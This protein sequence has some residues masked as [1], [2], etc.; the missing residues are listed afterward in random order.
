MWNN[1]PPANTSLNKFECL[2]NHKGHLERLAQT[3]AV[4]NNKTPKTPSFLKRKIRDAG[5]RMER[6]LKILYENKIISNRMEEISKKKSPYSPSLNIPSQCPAFELLGYHRLKINKVIDRENNKLYKRFTF[7]K[8]TLNSDKLNQE[9]K[10]NKYLE[11]NISKNKNRINPNLDFI[12]FEKFN[13]RLLTQHLTLSK[14]RRKRN[15]KLENIEENSKRLFNNKK[16]YIIPNLTTNFQN[17]TNILSNTEFED[18]V[19]N[20]SNE[21]KSF[22]K[23]DSLKRPNSCKPNIIVINREIQDNSKVF[24]SDYLFNNSNKRHKSKPG[25]GKTRTNGS[26][27][28]NIMT[29]P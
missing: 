10:Y 3:T 17:R 19:F 1:I 23:N 20:N 6:Y 11:Y 21:M 25:S 5:V 16:D 26:Y 27:S 18:N 15:I 12:E 28:T 4:I 22:K 8:P 7:T 9:Y 24:N 2:M 13:R 29:S 14:K